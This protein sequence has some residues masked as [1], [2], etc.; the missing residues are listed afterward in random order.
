MPLPYWLEAQVGKT[1]RRRR[2][3]R[4]THRVVFGTREA[5]PPVRATGGWQSNTACVERL[6]L[7][8]RQHG[9]IIGRRGTTLCQD[10]EGVRQ[11]LA[12]PPVDAHCGLPHASVR[13]SLPQP[14][15]TDGT[16]AATQWRPRS[17]AMAAGLT[18]HVGPL[19]EVR[20]WRVPPWPQPV[21]R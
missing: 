8:I 4:V 1:V 10:A 7:T 13:P 20:L 9:A 5:V 17:P 6:T 14:V 2:V 15:P 3:V 19:R 18:D 16:G 21:G 11:P 12:L